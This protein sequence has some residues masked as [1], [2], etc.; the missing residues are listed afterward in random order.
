MSGFLYI[1]K[2]NANCLAFFEV[3]VFLNIKTSHNAKCHAFCINT[4]ANLKNHEKLRNLKC[5]AFCEQKCNGTCL[6]IC[7]VSGFLYIYRRFVIFFFL[8]IYKRGR[9][10]LLMVAIV[11]YIYILK[12]FFRDFFIHKNQET[13]LF[14]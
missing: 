9:C 7:K 11:I 2:Q 5:L 8:Y 4:N 13:I 3:S 6:S 10:S 14:M 12:D 1:K